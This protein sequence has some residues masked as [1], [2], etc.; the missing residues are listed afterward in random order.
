MTDWSEEP[1][2]E[3][4]SKLEREVKRIPNL[5]MG[6]HYDDRMLISR[7]L[8]EKLVDLMGEEWLEEFRKVAQ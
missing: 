6:H 7:N 8:F 2:E 4:V 3:L 5:P 1:V